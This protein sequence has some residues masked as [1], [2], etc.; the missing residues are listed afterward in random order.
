MVLKQEAEVPDR[1]QWVLASC[2]EGIG[3]IAHAQKQIAWALRLLA[4]AEALRT[5]D[6]YRNTIG[7]EQSLYERLL[8]KATTQLGE[9]TFVALWTEGRS[10][11]TEEILAAQG[12]EGVF[13]QDPS[14]SSLATL[15]PPVMPPAG[16]T[17]REFEVLRLLAQGLMNVQIAER[18][19]ISVTTVNSYLSSIYSKLGVSSRLG[20]MRY[21]IDHHLS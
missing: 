17:R 2:L 19:V 8:A 7:R 21:A 20:A 13:S 15:L 4:R 18:L 16:L 5:S 9:A 6:T 14:T 12:L 11:T 10:M 3:E 1:V